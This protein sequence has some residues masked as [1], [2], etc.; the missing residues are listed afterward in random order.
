MQ[1]I[2]L[3]NSSFK[4]DFLRNWSKTFLSTFGGTI[5]RSLPYFWFLLH[6]RKF[7]AYG[8]QPLIMHLL[9]SGLRNNNSSL[10]QK[11]NKYE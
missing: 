3:K 1:E 4:E 6:S 9:M 10:N 8:P 2:S 5:K 11:I 7:L